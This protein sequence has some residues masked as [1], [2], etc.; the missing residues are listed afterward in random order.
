M[1]CSH[2]GRCRCHDR[3]EPVCSVPDALRQK[4]PWV[5]S[6]LART[7]GV[8]EM[9]TLDEACRVHGLDTNDIIELLN[10]TL[11]NTI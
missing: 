9:E 4:R 10:D 8:S 5:L 3:A 7:C 11:A 6:A 2:C 1:A